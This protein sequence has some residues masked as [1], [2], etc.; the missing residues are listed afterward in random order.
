MKGGCYFAER[1]FFFLSLQKNKKEKKNR[2]EMK[3]EKENIYRRD[4]VVC[5]RNKSSPDADLR[6]H[7]PRHSH[8]A[9]HIHDRVP[10]MGL[11]PSQPIGCG[12]SGVEDGRVR[13]GLVVGS[14]AGD[15][16]A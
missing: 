8:E 9:S 7:R 16:A 5:R 3:K 11:G 4:N 14:C 10:T 12:L 2:N 13:L 1:C 6:Q 15:D